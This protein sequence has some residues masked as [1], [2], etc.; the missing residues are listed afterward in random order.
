[1]TFFIAITTFNRKLYLQTLIESI[2]KYTSSHHNYIIAINDDGSEDG[3]REFIKSLKNTKNIQWLPLFSNNKGNHHATNNLLLNSTYHKYDFGFK[4]DDDLYFIKNGWEELYYN[5]YKESNY[6][7]LSHYSTDW[8]RPNQN[9]II[10]GKLISQTSASN[11]Q[12]AF[13]TFTPECISKV[14]FI[15]EI[16][17]GRR[18]SG[19]RDFSLRACRIGLNQEDTFWDAKGADNYIKLHPKKNYITTPNYDRELKIAKKNQYKKHK[20]LNTPNRTYIPLPFSKLNYLFDHV[21]LI[22]LKRR[23]D[24]LH[25]MKQSLNKLNIQYELIE[26]IDGNELTINSNINKPIIGCHLSHLKVYKDALSKKYEKPLILE[27][28]LLFLKNFDIPNL[29]NKYDLLYLG[30]SDYYF[31]SRKG[32]VYLAKNVDGT[33]A[34]SPNRNIIPKLI[35]LFKKPITKPCDTSLHAIQQKGNSFVIYPNIIIA[36]VSDSDIRQPR[37][38]IEHSKKLGWNPQNYE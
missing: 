23:P 3:S 27:D 35:E 28:D 6:P 7:H 25:K 1:M 32:N 21:Y 12:G 20:I 18:G 33:F 2:Q 10:S 8:E 13:Y 34:Y 36:D 17:F 9:T 31:N 22:N 24:R 15:D 4:I 38:L 14:G 11:S 5:A 37:N 19:H 26:A 16:N 30:A 29:P